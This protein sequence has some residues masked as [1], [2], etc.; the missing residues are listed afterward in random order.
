MQIMS[1][2]PLVGISSCLLGQ[3]V[4]YNGT[5]KYS[6][7]CVEQLSAW[8]EFVPTCPELGAGL[9]VPRPPIRLVGDAEAPKVWR[10]AD[11]AD[12][13]ADLKHYAAQRLP[14]LADL[15]GYVFIPNSPSCGVFNVKLYDALGKLSPQGSRG[16]FAAAFMQR[17]PGIPVVE[18]GQ[19]VDDEVRDHFLAR[20]FIVHAW[21]QLCREGL[22][23]AALV[24]F[25][26]RHKY[27]LMAH[28]S[29]RYNTL[30]QVLAQAGKQEPNALG[31]RYFQA[32]MTLVERPVTRRSNTNVLMHL[33]GYLKR[34]LSA[35]EKQQ[36]AALI[37]AY[38]LDQVELEEPVALLRLHFQRYPN[39]YI[40]QQTFL[41]PRL[42]LT[43]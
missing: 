35:E 29:G 33:Q 10:V 13:T 39:D 6:S 16:V 1:H 7:L 3:A 15:C 43:A 37:D 20:V 8:L 22:S 18:E 41:Q 19:L 34:F 12:V 25:H 24:R 14:E 21:R 2:K 31:E 30:G 40:D 36:L 28:D 17:F 23:A 26:S 27:T 9:G 11:G 32:L 4:R 42:H 5:H 38:R